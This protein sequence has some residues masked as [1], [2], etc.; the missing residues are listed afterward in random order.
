[1]IICITASGKVS[2]LAVSDLIQ[3]FLQPYTTDNYEP[4]DND[5]AIAQRLVRQGLPVY[6]L[7]RGLYP[8]A[9]DT[10]YAALGSTETAEQ[11][12]GGVIT[13]TGGVA[14]SPLIL[15][16]YGGI[17]LS[18]LG[19]SQTQ[20]AEIE[21]RIM[22]HAIRIREK[23]IHPVYTEYEDGLRKTELHPVDESED[24]EDDKIRCYKSKTGKIRKAGRSKARP[25]ENEVFLTEEE[26]AS[27]VQ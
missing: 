5:A 8:V 11:V 2:E 19:L 27:S 24:S 13:S 4:E 7:S 22:H 16:P 26:L 20:Q 15:E 1:M 21:K 9:L 12:Q 3:D 17:D 25:G 23:G 6:D 14:V 18:D 10:P